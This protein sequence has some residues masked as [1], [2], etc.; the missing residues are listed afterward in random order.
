MDRSDFA[1]WV[2]RYVTAWNSN[3]PG[4]IEGLFTEG[5][6]YLTE[7]Y[8]EPWQGR[9]Q[10]VRGWIDNKDEPGETTFS[11]EV[12]AVA[13]DLGFVR[14][15]TDYKTPPRTYDNLWEITL[16]EGGKATRY[17]EWWMKRPQDES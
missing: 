10:I 16:N 12:I 5:A 4:D 1:D 17:V 7:P 13:G 15:V 6:E 3:D 9:D 14:G 8:A 11:F 2:E